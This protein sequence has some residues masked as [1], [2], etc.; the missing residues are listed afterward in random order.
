MSS[1]QASMKSST[2]EST[3]YSKACS[4]RLKK[5]TWNCENRDLVR[6][7]G[8]DVHCHRFCN[9]RC[10]QIN[11][12]TAK[13]L[14]KCGV[15]VKVGIAI[16][17]SGVPLGKVSQARKTLFRVCRVRQQFPKFYTR[18]CFNDI[19]SRNFES[20]PRDAAALPS[21]R[22]LILR[23]RCGICFERRRHRLN[24]TVEAKHFLIWIFSGLSLISQKIENKHS[25]DVLRRVAVTRFDY[26]SSHLRIV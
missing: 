6:V 15:R 24:N 22:I 13:L 26:C 23:R 11:V 19:L 9:L 2:R 7:K 17:F 20:L 3:N 1:K 21:S 4:R 25:Q 5:S 10:S 16:V 8:A 18:I 12:D 14:L